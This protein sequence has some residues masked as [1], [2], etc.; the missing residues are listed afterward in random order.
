MHKKYLN[1]TKMEKSKK[2]E[3]ELYHFGKHKRS[4]DFGDAPQIYSKLD[5]NG[6]HNRNKSITI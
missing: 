6:K 3:L 2:N 5:T 4:D 1:K